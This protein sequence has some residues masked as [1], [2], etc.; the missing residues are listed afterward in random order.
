[1]I[2]H[3]P[4]IDGLVKES[5]PVIETIFGHCAGSLA[6]TSPN[7]LPARRTHVDVKNAA[8]VAPPPAAAADTARDAGGLP[9]ANHANPSAH[10]G[11]AVTG[12]CD[13]PCAG[14]NDRHGD[15][16]A[17]NGDDGDDGDRFTHTGARDCNSPAN[18]HPNPAARTHV[19]RGVTATRRPTDA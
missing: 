2:R 11:R 18:R 9:G 19:Y 14:D 17:A 10:A 13:D 16:G 8:F 4:V 6:F 3:N 5:L 7:R 1:M 15:R 12:G